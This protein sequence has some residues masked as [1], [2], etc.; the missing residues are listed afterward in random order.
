MYTIGPSGKVLGESKDENLFLLGHVALFN[1]S[2]AALKIK[3]LTI[4][5]VKGYH[6]IDHVL[7]PDTSTV[8][9]R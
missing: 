5:A 1:Q 6:E 4:L 8:T 2:Y 9:P 3:A 7:K